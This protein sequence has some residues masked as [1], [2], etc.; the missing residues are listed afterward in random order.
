MVCICL[1]IFAPKASSVA[2]EADWHELERQLAGRLHAATPLAR[3]CFTTYHG[4]AVSADH[5][6]CAVVESNYLN[7]SFRADQYAGFHYL[8]G[9]GCISN[10]ADQCHLDPGNPEASPAAGSRCRQGLVS[11]RYVDIS[12]AEDVQAAF[13]FARRTGTPLSI[14]ASGHDYINRNS[15]RGSL[16]LWTRNLGNMTYHPSFQPQGGVG[17]P[18]PVQ[19]ITFGA[20]VSS[21]EAQ[22]FAGHHN[23]TLAGPS[24]PG[25]AVVGGWTLFGGH[26]VL[27]PT[28]GLGADR[29]LEMEIVTPDG[30]RRRC[31]Q[32]ANADLFWALRGAGAGAF[33]LVLSVTV[34]VE[35]AMA[36]TLVLLSFPPTAENQPP[37]ISLLINNTRAWSA[38]GWGGPMTSS[39]VA[40]VSLR[41]DEHAATK[42]MAPVAEY[43]RRQ[44]G[45]VLIQQFPTFPDFY[46]QYIAG[47]STN[48]ATG[49][50][51]TIRVLPRRFHNKARGKAQLEGFLSRRAIRGQTPYIFLTAPAQYNHTAGS[52]SMHPAWRDSYWLTGFATAYAWNATVAERRARARQI[53]QLSADL[54]RLAPDG[55]TY[56]N[57]A[58]PWEKNWQREFWGTANYARLVAIKARYDPHGLL[59]CW[60]CVGFE[61]AWIHTDPAFACM[62]AFDGLV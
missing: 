7:A 35:P 40:L 13:R 37:F 3:P 22:A 4:Q 19:A 53:Q 39:S 57:E 28:L 17:K 1:S 52:T 54:Q 16:A 24:A 33:G 8:Q 36:T 56:T 34:K 21:D 31:N 49:A 27:S 10:P 5:D 32:G 60:R 51:I 55:A 44:N 62:G 26:S 18:G 12:S 15:L 2:T 23:V 30:R 59:R 45:T 38:S 50:L 48:L 11:R 58:N 47:S 29:V 25:I 14:K 61:D 41:Q 42:A 20:G 9:D 46:A 43:V 6:Q